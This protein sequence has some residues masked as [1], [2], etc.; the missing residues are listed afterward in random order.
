[1]LSFKYDALCCVGCGEPNLHHEK[2]EVFYRDGEDAEQGY[3]VVCTHDVT[4]G[5][6]MIGNPSRRR[7]G[8]RIVFNCEHCDAKTEL[9]IVQHK[10]STYLE[11][12]IVAPSKKRSVLIE[13]YADEKLSDI[14]EAAH[15]AY[16]GT[17]E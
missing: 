12:G 16:L 11:Q 7:D 17:E 6:S 2:V 1:M 14:I 13:R 8:V 9:T 5:R 15:R 4:I 3:H 10:G